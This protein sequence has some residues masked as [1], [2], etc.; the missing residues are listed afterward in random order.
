MRNTKPRQQGEYVAMK[1][2]T[3]EYEIYGYTSG[4][5]DF[6]VTEEVAQLEAVNANLLEALKG[7]NELGKFIPPAHITNYRKAVSE[8]AIKAIA[9][10]KKIKP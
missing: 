9:N 6:N 3:D 8:I 1:K 2:L 5:D 4:G 10:A 7:I